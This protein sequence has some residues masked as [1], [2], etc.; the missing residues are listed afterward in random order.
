MFFES[1]DKLARDVTGEEPSGTG[2]WMYKFNVE[3]QELTYLAGVAGPIIASAADGSRLMFVKYNE[4]G[5]TLNFKVGGLYLWSAGGITKVASLPKP[6]FN[7]SNEG[8]LVVAS[9][10]APAEGS[11][12]VFDTDAAIPEAT[13]SA[14][15]GPANNGGGY[16]Q[17]YRYDVSTA[18][19]RCLSC[20]GQGV[21]PVGDANLSNDDQK[22]DAEHETGGGTIVGSRG[23]TANGEQVFFDTPEAL[24]PQD[25]NGVRDVYEW[26]EGNVHLISSGTNPL[27]SFFL[28]NSE[29]GSDVFF[30]T[31]AGLAPSDTDGGYDVYDA[32]IG[33]GFPQEPTPS[34]CMTECQGPP[35]SPP[36][37]ANPASAAFSGTGNLTT[38]TP[39]KTVT[40]KRK[41]A[42][43][44]K[45]EKLARALKACKKDSKAKRKSC[46]AAARK[47]YSPKA[48]S[49]KGGR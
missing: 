48:M 35:A 10:R 42:A 17:V 41:T 29:S 49:H 1:A 34:E 31:A 38:P 28:D 26:E 40:P 15:T 2:P 20:T 32:R 24:V 11:I 19:L 21:T 46:E 9:A 43:Q 13:N 37:F 16:E 36:S 4:E 6:S 23:M 30:A 8:A 18:E 27:P 22:Q 5:G 33:E 7:E 39:T 25:V 14:G 45:A 47:R 44:V 3:T 12:F